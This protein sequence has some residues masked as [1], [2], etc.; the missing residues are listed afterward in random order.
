V[1]SVPGVLRLTD[2]ELD[3]ASGVRVLP[4]TTGVTGY[5]DGAEDYLY[6]RMKGVRDRSVGSDELGSLVHDWAT[7]YHLT[8]Y[9]STIFDCL[10]LSGIAGRRVLE[11]GAGMGAIT[12]WLGQQGAHVHAIEGSMARASVARLRTEDLESVEVYASNF[13]HFAEPGMFDMVTLIGVLEYSHLYHPDHTEP[14]AAAAANLR[15][16]AEALTEDGVLVLAI[17]NR[18]GLKYLNA[19]REDHSGRLFEGIQGYPWAQTPVTFNLR[20]LEGL[21]ADAG[22]GAV[23][24]LVP[25]PDYKLATTV[26]N[27]D[28]CGDEERIHNWMAAPAPG[29][30]PVREG[31]LYNETLA[32]REIAEAGLLKE[33]ANSHL[34][35]AYRGDAGRTADRLGIDLDWSARHY[36]LGRRAGLRKR[37]TLS[38]ATVACD[39]RPL[40][41]D[42]GELTAARAAMQEF[43]I[44]YQAAD[45]AHRRGDLV[46]LEVL[47]DLIAEGL[48]ERFKAQLRRYRTWL[49]DEFGT[50]EG[51]AAPLVRGEAFDATWWNVVADPETGEWHVID[52]EWRLERPVPADYV[53]WRMLRWFFRG[54]LV[55]LPN[56]L[57]A[58][59][60]EPLVTFA[61]AAAGA[62][63][64]ADQLAAFERAEDEV[65]RAI[66][67]G[68]LPT[69]PSEALA[70]LERVADAPRRFTVLALADDV[71]AEPALLSAYAAQF[72]P[73]DSA[74]LV[75]YAP[76]RDPEE[77]GELVGGALSAAG[78]GDDGPDMMLVAVEEDPQFELT[79][80][81][82]ASVL[83]A[84]DEPLGAFARLPRVCG[85][86]ARDLRAFAEAVWALG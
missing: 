17:E 78:V 77:A 46:L 51:G 45:E 47:G 48:G 80:A 70:A 67:P 18:L 57:R 71:V 11:L 56:P 63:L 26:I 39:T 43:G 52:T 76:G 75:I 72:T 12:R 41:E 54:H 53:L 34:V 22:F 58:Q 74:T 49:V 30:G 33:L 4:G 44:A 15:M 50:G 5:R 79:V 86:D 13:S 83:L 36:S 38:G 40:G 27:P 9:R 32:N 65:L 59:G 16:A 7:Q 28:R 64:T 66:A 84:D 1:S 21:L 24:T 10:G 19:A 42:A 35:L 25:Y 82:Q 6:E 61:L 85:R 73:E 23:Q 81:L 2:F 29:R 8:A 20:R 69:G 55:Q 3:R 60:V 14:Y 68:P 31:T 37:I 62:E